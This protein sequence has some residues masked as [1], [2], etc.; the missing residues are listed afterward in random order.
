M[1]HVPRT[2]GALSGLLIVA[3]G[4][5]GALI[6]FVG[7]YFDFGFTTEAWTWTAIH[8]WLSLLPGIAAVV[9]GLILLGSG[10]RATAAIGAAIAVVAGV[11]FIVGP[12]L[13]E[14]WNPGAL[15]T[16]LG[17]EFRQAVILIS[18][19][20]G[21]GA[22]I[23]F[24]GSSALGR[25]SVVGVRDVA[26]ARNRRLGMAEPAGRHARGHRRHAHAGEAAGA[27]AAVG[28]GAA[29]GAEYPERE[30]EYPEREYPERAGRGAAEREPLEAGRDVSRREPVSGG[31][32]DEASV[33][34]DEPHPYE[35]RRSHNGHGEQRATAGRDR[36]GY[37][38]GRRDVGGRDIDGRESGRYDTGGYADGGYGDSGYGGYEVGKHRSGERPATGPER[39]RPAPG[40]TDGERTAEHRPEHRGDEPIGAGSGARSHRHHWWERH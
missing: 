23:L 30:H 7:P 6:P 16:P 38:T 40:A 29:A 33:Y 3:A 17:G 1:L 21:L 22:L 25:L 20:Y 26:A 12:P 8:F 13:S 10:N 24:L 27:G 39:G 2:R 15:G 11:W 31:R 28:A 32:Y 4:I 37:E 19:F 5:W 18:F 36:G 35:P 14:I 9:A 34:P